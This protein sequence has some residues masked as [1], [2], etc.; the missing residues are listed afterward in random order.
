[1]INRG[2]LAKTA[3]RLRATP[4]RGYACKY[5]GS[6]EHYSYTCF[7]RPQKPIVVESATHK[8]KR[9]ACRKRWL[10]MK[11]NQPDENG[12]WACYLGIAPD[13]H[14][15]INIDTISLEHVRAKVR[16][17]KLRYCARAIKAACPPCNKLKGSWSIQQLAETYPHIAAMIVTP[18]W[19]AYEAELDLLEEKL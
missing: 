7:K 13:C 8:A 15:H 18:E 3:Y 17:P 9:R 16:S 11:S 14:V 5:C 1:M 2:K 19:I 4:K 6:H 10:R 12:N